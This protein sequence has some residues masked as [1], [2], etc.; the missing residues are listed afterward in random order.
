[1]TVDDRWYASGLRFTCTRCSLCCRFESGYVW[2]SRSDVSRLASGLGLTATQVVRR[3]CRPVDVG[4]FRQLSLAE[5]PNGDCVFW[6]DGGCTVY[7]WRPRQCSSYPFWAPYLSSAQEWE[8]VTAECPGAGVGRLYTAAEVDGL[9]AER[10]Y[11]PPLNADEVDGDV[12]E[13]S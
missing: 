6:R 2:L 7:P 8:H 13:D 3:F 9:L 4:G 11:E 10:R 12:E 5:Q 1:M